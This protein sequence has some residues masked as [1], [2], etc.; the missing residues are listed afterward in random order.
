MY[1][2]QSLIPGHHIPQRSDN[3]IVIPL[4]RRCI[5]VRRA[6]VCS[7]ASAT[8]TAAAAD[9]GAVAAVAAAAAAAAARRR[10]S[11]LEHKKRD[12]PRGY[13]SLLDLERP[14]YAAQ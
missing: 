12:G 8:V 5:L 2:R 7:L 11:N 9:D 14:R 6:S 10:P 13:H 3:Y 1:V 4:A